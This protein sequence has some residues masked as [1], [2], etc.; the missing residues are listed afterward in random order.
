MRKVIA[1]AAHRSDDPITSPYEALAG[2]AN[3][4]SLRTDEA[5]SWIPA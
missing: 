2:G 5:D 4:S 3:G 1:I